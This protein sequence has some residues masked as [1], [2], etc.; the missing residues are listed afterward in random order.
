MGAM[1]LEDLKQMSI[2]RSQIDSQTVEENMDDDFDSVSPEDELV[3]L[4]S[5]MRSLKLHEIPVVEGGKFQGMVSYGTIMKRK[6]LSLET[7]ARTLMD[8]VPTISLDTPLTEV[9]EHMMSSNARQLPVIKGNRVIGIISRAD[10]VK[11]VSTIRHLKEIKVWEI[12][13]DVVEYVRPGDRLEDALDIMRR[14]DVRTIPVLDDNKQVH[15]IIGM[16]EVINYNYREKSRQTVGELTGV[17]APVELEVG[18]LCVEDPFTIDWE[19]DLGMASS[20]MADN[21]ISTLPV[22]EDDKLVGI[23][24]RY[25]II[26]LMAACREREVVF[27][28]ITGLEDEDRYHMPT[29]DKEI[30]NELS[31]VAKIFTPNTFVMHVSKYNSEGA[32]AKYSISGRL[33]AGGRLFRA[34]AVDWDLVRTTEELMKKLMGMV[35]DA[36]EQ[37]DDPRKRPMR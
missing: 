17:K 29:L 9:A 30:G 2:L 14:L 26:E 20:I 33:T 8:N 24:T 34:K 3:D 22:T 35:S 5:L 4:L 27:V 12:M 10:L 11:W 21:D 31:K 7:K 16:K 25:D 15:G 1:D 37:R 32:T 13:S 19:D 6:N 28:Q 23:I 18:S 36:K